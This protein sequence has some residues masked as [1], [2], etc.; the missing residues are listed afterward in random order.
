MN[1]HVQVCKEYYKKHL[2]KKTFFTTIKEQVD[3]IYKNQNGSLF[4]NIKCD[5]K[6]SVPISFIWEVYIYYHKVNLLQGIPR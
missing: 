2:L 1:S 3:E 5:K 6:N 4:D